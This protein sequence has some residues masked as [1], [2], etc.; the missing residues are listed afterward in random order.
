M[1]FPKK[2]LLISLSGGKI[3]HHVK[4]DF[5]G[6]KKIFDDIGIKKQPKVKSSDRHFLE[7]SANLGDISLSS[8]RV[9]RTSFVLKE[10]ETVQT[11]SSNVRAVLSSGFMLLGI[12]Y[13]YPV[14]VGIK[15]GKPNLPLYFESMGPIYFKGTRLVDNDGEIV[16]PY[17]EYA[18]D[19]SKWQTG[20]KK[21]CD[22]IPDTQE[23]SRTLSVYIKKEP[24]KFKKK[25]RP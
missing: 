13:F 1:L 22:V 23:I 25:I 4:P 6:H 19:K 10:S 11:W 2:S 18:E 21:S 17:I 3:A 9:R 14:Y 24:R 7:I 5:C 16:V 15:N 20:F 8:N 12:E